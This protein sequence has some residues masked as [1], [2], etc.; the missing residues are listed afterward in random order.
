MAVVNCGIRQMGFSVIGFSVLS[1]SMLKN[2]PM[3]MV[4]TKILMSAREQGS[5]LLMNPDI[6]N[7]MPST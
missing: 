2:K 7:S 3:G 5:T 4:T 6:E 1:F